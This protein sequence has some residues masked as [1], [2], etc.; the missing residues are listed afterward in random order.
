[1]QRGAFGAQCR[2]SPQPPRAAC[3]RAAIHGAARTP[4]TWRVVSSPFFGRPAGLTTCTQWGH[5]SRGLRAA[6]GR[7]HGGGACGRAV[8]DQQLACR[9][10]L[11]RCSAPRPSGAPAQ[12]PPYFAPPRALLHVP[13]PL[14][15]GA[16]R[17]RCPLVPRAHLVALHHQVPEAYRHGGQLQARPAGCQQGARGRQCRS[18]RPAGLPVMTGSAPTPAGLRSAAPCGASSRCGLS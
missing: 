13:L 14:M 4:P 2:P 12:H 17:W 8:P 3:H 5:P 11:H 9:A 10:A 1:M 18:R 6:L 7:P 15:A 16:A